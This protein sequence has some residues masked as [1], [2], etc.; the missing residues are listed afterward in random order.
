MQLINKNSIIFRRIEINYWIT[1]ISNLTLST[2]SFKK[3]FLFQFVRVCFVAIINKF[4]SYSF[5]F[6][7]IH[8]FSFM[9]Q[10]SIK[11]RKILWRIMQ[12]IIHWIIYSYRLI[13]K[14][15]FKFDWVDLTRLAN[16]KFRLELELESSSNLLAC[17]KLKL[18]SNFKLYY[19]SLSLIWLK[20]KSN[21]VNLTWVWK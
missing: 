21:F 19:Q 20:L 4:S 14:S 13:V 15:S 12:T 16:R 18:D 11:S 3:K 8:Q 1:E 17:Q 10:T 5:F 7:S 9:S 6:F 2:R